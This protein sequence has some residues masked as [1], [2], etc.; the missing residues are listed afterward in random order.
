[1]ASTGESRRRRIGHGG[2][3]PRRM[4]KQQELALFIFMLL[5]LIAL[6]AYGLSA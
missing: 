4:T 1:M 5:V 3:A 2:E 6:I